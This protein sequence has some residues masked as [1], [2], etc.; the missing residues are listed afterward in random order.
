[1]LLLSPLLDW[2]RG[3]DHHYQTLTQCAGGDSS[4]LDV[5]GIADAADATICLGIMIAWLRKAARCDATEM[6]RS[7]QIFV[8]LFAAMT[9]SNFVLPVI[10]LAIPMIRVRTICIRP[11]TAVL[12]G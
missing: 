4:W 7:I 1:M 9:I 2:L 6:R 3:G 8:L 11:V 12:L 5:H 10:A